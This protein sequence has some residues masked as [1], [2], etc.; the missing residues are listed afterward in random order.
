MISP[1]QREKMI[2]HYTKS[3]AYMISDA[4]FSRYFAT[5]FPILKYAELA[6][7]SS[8]DELIP[9]DKGAVIIL[10]ESRRNEGHWC[11]LLKYDDKY[12]WTD[13][14]GGASG[15]PDGELSFIGKAMKI[16]L[17]ED[18]HYLSKL[19]K[20]SGKKVIYN[21]EKFQS[22]SDGVN[23]CGKWVIARLLMFNCGYNLKDFQE[24]IN[25]ICERTGKPADICVC[26]L[27]KMK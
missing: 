13:S 20:E 22:L 23:T 15:K 6:S 26:D 10:T 14:Y 24:K 11:C 8:L 19:L 5:Q 27:V 1:I 3:L 4:D 9:G 25:S 12:E 17:G 18:N 7:V 2:D 16:M 21:K